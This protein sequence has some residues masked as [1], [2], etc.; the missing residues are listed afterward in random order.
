MKLEGFGLK[1]S[2]KNN[3]FSLNLK[4]NRS[5][6]RFY[7]TFCQWNNARPDRSMKKKKVKAIKMI[8]HNGTA[9]LQAL[10]LRGVT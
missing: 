9:I 7:S 4:I 10:I 3:F 2:M 1:N 5:T 6:E 8:F